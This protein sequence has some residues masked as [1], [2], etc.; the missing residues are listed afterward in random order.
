MRQVLIL[1]GRYRLFEDGSIYRI[2]PNGVEIQLFQRPANYKYFTICYCENGKT[3]HKY[4]HRLV[5]QYFV[6]NPRNAQIVH[7]KDGNRHNNAASNLEWVTPREHQTK[8]HPLTPSSSYGLDLRCE[9]CGAKLSDW[10]N[11]SRIC[12]KCKRELKKKARLENICKERQRMIE[13]YPFTALTAAQ[14]NVMHLWL[15]GKG[16]TEIAKAL[17]FSKQNAFSTVQNAIN[18]MKR[19]NTY[20]EKQFTA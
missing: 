8:K 18:R 15:A 5:A 3:Y 19:R 10:H 17:G 20:D 2:L 11:K 4:I 14:R 6:P 9:V 13:G 16:Y 12:T 1:D 7:H